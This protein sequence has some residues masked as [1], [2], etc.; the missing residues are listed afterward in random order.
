[1]KTPVRVAVTGAAGNIGYAMLFRIA[2]GELFGPEQPV[3]L[4][5]LEITPAMKALEG[6]AMELDDC[7]FPL[8]AE[9]VLTDDPARAFADANWCLLVGA[10]P[11]GKG[12]ERKELLTANGPIFT[13]QGR[14]INDNAA[15]DVRVLVVGNPANTNCLI[16]MHAAPDLP[17]E[18]FAA[19]TMLDHNR[20]CAQLAT[21]AGV[22]VTDVKKMTIWGNHSSTQYPD[23][24]HAEIGGR[25]AAEVI[26]DENWIREQF[27]PTVQKRGA[28]I[29]GAR[30]QSSAA[31]AANAAME[32][33][34]MWH[35][36]TPHGDWTSM[37]IPSNSAYDS[38]PGVIFSYPVKVSGGEVRVVEDLTLSDFDRQKL[39]ATGAELLEE[40]AAVESLLGSR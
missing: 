19:M 36:G 10:R 29:I 23:A 32:H 2:S 24:Y 27:I 21:R 40:R 8:L 35:S 1:M 16:A 13:G 11:R 39:A 26:D 17:P 38:P 3:A 15:S 34:R 5:L 25:T 18:R 4:Q 12:M 37:A 28:A 7:A 6:V 20:A 14:A 31:S 9:T 33:V 22:A 30:G